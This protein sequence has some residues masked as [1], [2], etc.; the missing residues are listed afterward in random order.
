MFLLCCIVEITVPSYITFFA[1]THFTFSLHSSPKRPFSFFLQPLIHSFLHCL[2]VKRVWRVKICVVIGYSPSE[3]GQILDRAGN[4]YRLWILG[5]LIG[6]IGDR[7]RSGKTGA[8]GV[9]GENDN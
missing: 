9:P 3:E 6:W 7:T 2:E 4:G 1:S 5:D 8:F